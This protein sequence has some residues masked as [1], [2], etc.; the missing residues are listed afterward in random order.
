MYIDVGAP[1]DENRWLQIAKDFSAPAHE[2]DWTRNT[3]DQ[4]ITQLDRVRP[5]VTRGALVAVMAVLF[6]MIPGTSYA[7][8]VLLLPAVLQTSLEIALEHSARAKTAPGH[9]NALL[10]PLMQLWFRNYERWQIN[11][12]GLLGAVAVACNVAA[13]VF[14]TGSLGHGPVKVAA[15]GVSILYMNSGL[16][17]PLLDATVYS[18]LQYTPKLLR[19]IRPMIWLAFVVGLVGLVAATQRWGSAWAPDALPYAYMACLLPYALGLRI[20]EYERALCAGGFVVAEAQNDANRRAGLDMHDLLQIFKGPLRAALDLEGLKPSSRMGLL[21]FM[22]NVEAIYERARDQSID[23]QSGIMP[24]LKYIVRNICRPAS[25]KSTTRIQIDNLD[26]ANAGFA[27]QLIS[28]LTHNAVQ[29]YQRDFLVHVVRVIDVQAYVEGD[30]IFV[31]V[32]DSL[33]P[34]TADGWCRP[35]STMGFIREKLGK[36]GGDLTQIATPSGGKSIQASWNIQL[37][38]LRK[39]APPEVSDKE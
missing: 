30:Q 22:T 35:G 20:R 13:A 21:T 11:V 14:F 25:V 2:S 8:W 27:K 24:P 39:E 28:T 31:S 15:F 12:T 26:D 4:R 10:R 37:A 36:H 18:P 16:A 23:L 17:G 32:T 38:P 6:A 3:T 33:K 19:R 9:D 29:A 5:F 1:R 7:A 34:I